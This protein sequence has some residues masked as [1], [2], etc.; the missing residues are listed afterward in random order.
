[1]ATRRR[2]NMDIRKKAML[3]ALEKSLGIVAPA[4]VVA[5]VGR[6]TFYEWMDKD[7]EFR[8]AVG[9]MQ[10]IALD[11]AESKLMKRIKDED[12]ASIIFFLKCRAKNRGYVERQEIEHSGKI[13]YQAIVELPPQDPRPE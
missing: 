7:P 9:G 5:G 2:T 11:F 8:A 12:T 6:S 10:D 13:E 3:E 1:M 4:C